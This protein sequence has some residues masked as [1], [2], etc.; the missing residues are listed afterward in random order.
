MQSVDSIDLLIAVITVNFDNRVFAVA[1]V[2]AIIA[3]TFVVA[4]KINVEIEK[5]PLPFYL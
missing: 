2:V 5:Y 1:V 4:T 3:E